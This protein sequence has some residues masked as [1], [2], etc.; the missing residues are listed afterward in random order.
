MN[1]MNL[2]YL[3]YLKNQMN[4]LY[5]MNLMNQKYLMNLKSR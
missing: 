1:L 4:H 5:Q 3:N 2:K